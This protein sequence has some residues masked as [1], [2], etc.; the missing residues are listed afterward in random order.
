MQPKEPVEHPRFPGRKRSRVRVPTVDPRGGDALLALGQ[1]G[2][3][4]SGIRAKPGAVQGPGGFRSSSVMKS[5][6]GRLLSAW[7]DWHR[8][9]SRMRQVTVSIL[10]FGGAG[11]RGVGHGQSPPRDGSAMK[12]S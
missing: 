9:T 10:A 11:V 6:S 1:T 4:Q 2:L 3:E 5:S 12:T 7:E 8:G